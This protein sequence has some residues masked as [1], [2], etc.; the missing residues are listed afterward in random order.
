MLFQNT[1]SDFRLKVVYATTSSEDYSDIVI[2]LYYTS[3]SSIQ[4]Y[5]LD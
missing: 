3:S 1:A 4:L 2:L 5:S